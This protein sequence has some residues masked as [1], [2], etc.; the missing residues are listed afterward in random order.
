[1][2][3]IY[4]ITLDD[5][6][7]LSL[8]ISSDIREI[9]FWLFDEVGKFDEQ[10]I[11]FDNETEINQQG[12]IKNDLYDIPVNGKF[13]YQFASDLD[14]KNKLMYE[15]FILSDKTFGFTVYDGTI[16]DS[17]IAVLLEGVLKILKLNYKYKIDS[18]TYDDKNIKN[19]YAA[20]KKLLENKEKEQV[21]VKRRINLLAGSIP[22]LLGF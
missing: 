4:S 18:I 22:T 16:S 19:R 14:A 8:D 11:C 2:K 1:M 12:L 6:V 15:P 13:M 10:I 5:D 3:R 7:P 20:I 21:K 17:E 9:A